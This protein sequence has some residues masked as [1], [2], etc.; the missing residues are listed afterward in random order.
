ML[1]LYFVRTHCLTD[2]LIF[3]GLCGEFISSHEGRIRVSN[4]PQEDEEVHDGLVSLAGYLH[5]EKPSRAVPPISAHQAD[6]PPLSLT[7]LLQD[8]IL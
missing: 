2:F 5:S 7:S 1:S 4:V 6:A 3:M 8:E